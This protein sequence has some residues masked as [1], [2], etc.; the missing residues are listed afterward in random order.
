MDTFKLRFR[1]AMLRTL[2]HEYD[3]WAEVTNRT[4]EEE[5][6]L[7]GDVFDVHAHTHMRNTLSWLHAAWES[8]PAKLIRNAWTSSLYLS[9]LEPGEVEYGTALGNEEDISAYAELVSQMSQKPALQKALGIEFVK[10]PIQLMTELLEFD[11]CEVTG[12]NEVVKDNDIVIESLA[13]QGLLRD[14][15]RASLMESI[16]SDGMSVVTAREATLS[17]NQLLQFI[18]QES[19]NLLTQ[20]ERRTG[21][22]NLLILQ[23]LLLKACERELEG[24]AATD[25]TV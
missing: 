13:A 19:D 20:P 14:T 7:Q 16:K 17:L 4:S 3:Q 10:S 8:V 22:A 23:R 15:P 1:R 2:L 12:E 11:K 5:E 24:E 21:R 18:S 25:F 6:E 9:A